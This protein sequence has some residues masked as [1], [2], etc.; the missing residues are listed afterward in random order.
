MFGSLD[1]VGLHNPFTGL[2]LEQVNRVGGMVPQQVIG[3]GA[4]LA[5]GVGVRPPEKVGLDVHLLDGELA[6]ADP[7]VHVLVGGVE[8]PGVAGHGDEAGFLLN[9]HDFLYARQ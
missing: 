2:V 9:V 8:A 6:R 4:G 3:P 7:V 5:E 1:G